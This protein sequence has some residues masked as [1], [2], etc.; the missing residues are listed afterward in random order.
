MA[1]EYQAGVNLKINDALGSLKKLEREVDKL[2]RELRSSVAQASKTGAKDIS[3][4]NKKASQSF[5]N[6]SNSA[7]K[8]NKTASSAS[9]QTAK[10]NK[11]LDKT[12]KNT[13]KLTELW[14][15]F[16][17]VGLGF[18]AVYQAVN[19]TVMG[20]QELSSVYKEG[21]QQAGELVST[22]AKVAMWYSMATDGAIS[23]A[24]AFERARVN[25]EALADA[26]VRSI[27]S[28]SELATGLDEVGQAGVNIGEDLMDGFANLIDFTTLVAQ[29]TG[30]TTRQVR[31]ELQALMQGQM[32]TTNILIRTAKHLGVITEEQIAGLK[33]Q[34]G[35]LEAIRDII[36][37]I[38]ETW[39]RAK[40]QMIISDV[41][42]GFKMWRD[43]LVRIVSKSEELTSKQEGTLSIFGE[44]AYE[45]FDRLSEKLDQV[46]DEELG[47]FLRVVNYGFDKFLTLSENAVYFMGD[48]GDAIVANERAFKEFS[49]ILEESFSLM[50]E[51]GV[52]VLSLMKDTLE[53]SYTALDKMSDLPGA[54]SNK[55]II[56][57]LLIGSFLGKLGKFVSV[58]TVIN[59]LLERAND[60]A[61]GYFY[62]SLQEL[63]ASWERTKKYT[64]LTL[65]S[66]QGI[67]KEQNKLTTKGIALGLDDTSLEAQGQAI[68]KLENKLERLKKKSAEA[69]ES[70]MLLFGRK[71]TGGTGE[72]E[73]RQN[74]IER[75]EKLLKVVWKRYNEAS[76]AANA[77]RKATAPKGGLDTFAKQKES[78]EKI[79]AAFDEA[80]IKAEYFFDKLKDKIKA[81]ETPTDLTVEYAKQELNNQIN[82]LESIK[83][84]IEENLSGYKDKFGKTPLYEE[85][86]RQVAALNVNI[87]DTQRKLKAVET[88]NFEDLVDLLEKSKKK[89]KDFNDIIRQYKEQ[90]LDSYTSQLVSS[91]KSAGGAYEELAEQIVN[92]N[93][94]WTDQKEILSGLTEEQKENLRTLLKLIRANK[95]SEDLKER[96]KEYEKF[97]KDYRKT[98]MDSYDL[99]RAKI[100][101]TT[102]EYKEIL[103]ALGKDTSKVD[104]LKQAQLSKVNKKQSIDVSWE[105]IKD[106]S[107]M[108]QMQTG[109][110]SGFEQMKQDA[111][112]FAS[113]AEE[114]VTSSADAM[115]DALTDF[116]TKGK[117]DWNE[118]ASTVLNLITKMMVKY[119]MFQAIKAAGSMAA[120]GDGAVMQNGSM[121]GFANGGVVS[122]PT[123][124]P[125]ANGT[126]LMGE[127][128]PEAIMPLSRTRTGELGVKIDERSGSGQKES[129]RVE[130]HFHVNVQTG[131]DGKIAQE[132]MQQMQRK[133]S[134]TVKRVQG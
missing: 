11:N 112:N 46:T 108:E 81:G 20:L 78:V 71:G 8:Y 116:I 99:E 130:Q 100:R 55:G 34:E 58:L 86:K 1:Y 125:M 128:G 44:T 111:M 102:K 7:K 96:K 66:I 42:T 107:W 51:T 106:Q 88:G 97:Q 29:T 15:R 117:A 22:Q 32:R 126:G 30:S 17:K 134:R 124:F 73:K 114:A 64:Q 85:A 5:D 2:K 16:G 127:E 65:E 47:N 12:N 24:D 33:R 28:L 93:L 35:R 87:T 68:I 43:T 74:E 129:K 110:S 123:I 25:T 91:L 131:P 133:L 63:S 45:H 105:N 82:Q 48:V 79:K 6:L 103:K 60:L 27:S 62:P 83:N 49:N 10:L 40:K 21:I 19:A 14:Q 4:N 80:S 70:G 90:N 94:V 76:E 61:G 132:S 23:Y 50:K 109:V 13:S 121:T 37:G 54:D 9:D 84:R 38:G 98:F 72:S 119:L 113:M 122:Q 53:A 18:T 57:T 118:L 120:A 26:S 59:T 67:R 52:P 89:T 115:S 69:S 39:Q 3:K 101:E 104:R 95:E 77:F 56:G 36:E 75:L 41:N 92:N 31:Q